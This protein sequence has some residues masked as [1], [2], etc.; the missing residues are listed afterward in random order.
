MRVCRPW[1]VCP[2][3]SAEEKSPFYL[4]NQADSG[5]KKGI[6]VKKRPFIPFPAKIERLADAG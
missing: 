3:K 1:G 6:F 5:P 4:Q 2:I